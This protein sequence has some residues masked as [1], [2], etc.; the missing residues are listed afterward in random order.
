MPYRILL[1]TLIDLFTEINIELSKRPK[2]QKSMMSTL[3]FYEINVFMI[4]WYKE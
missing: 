2:M 1:A 4:H 3:F